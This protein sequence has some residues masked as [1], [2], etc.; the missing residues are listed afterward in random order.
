LFPDFVRNSGTFASSASR[1]T[2]PP[3]GLPMMPPTETTFSC[4]V[5][6]L[7]PSMAASSALVVRDG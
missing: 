2:A 5:S 4:W 1:V 3:M 6:L 7:K